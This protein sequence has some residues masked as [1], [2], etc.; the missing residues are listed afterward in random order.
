M[1]QNTATRR[2]TQREGATWIGG[3]A[4]WLLKPIT[5]RNAKS[6]LATS[7]GSK[8]PCS[9]QQIEPTVQSYTF[10]WPAATAADPEIV[11][12][13]KLYL[14]EFVENVFGFSIKFNH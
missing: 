8:K 11:F 6:Y 13:G 10:D 7:C 2:P 9:T 4:K 3:V 14:H 5:S 1:A 12:L